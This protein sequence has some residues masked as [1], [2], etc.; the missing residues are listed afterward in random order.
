MLR[1][2][3]QFL[4]RKYSVVIDGKAVAKNVRISMKEEISALKAQNPS[5]RPRLAIIQVGD[6]KDS[7][8]YVG[9]KMKATKEIGMES[10]KVN[11]DE[12]VS[13]EVL[14]RELKSLNE[15]P[16]VHGIIVQM[17]LPK[18]IDSKLVINEISFKKDVDG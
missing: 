10:T 16:N 12:S 7:S 5:F 9:Q 14:L 15:D 4:L 2:R 17:P 6:R 11:L 3:S 1:A 8:S 18:H 13:Q